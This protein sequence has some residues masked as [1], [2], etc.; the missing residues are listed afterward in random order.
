MQLLG[1]GRTAEVFLAQDGRAL[2]LF[3]ADFPAK[4]IRREADKARV[5]T[6]LCSF[7]PAF[8]GET[9]IDGRAGLLY[10]RIDGAPLIDVE[11][12]FDDPPNIES[13]ARE[14]AQLQLDI[15]AT[16]S[17]GLPTMAE[18][19]ATSIA[20]YPLISAAGRERLL[21]FVA[22]NNTAQLCHGDLH[23]DNILRQTD[24]RLRVID[25]TNA[26]SGHPLCDLERTLFMIECGLVPGTEHIDETE[27]PL[28]NA[29]A[30]TYRQAYYAEN[31]DRAN[32]DIW[33][34]LALVGRH[35]EGIAGERGIAE[36]RVREVL[37]RRGEFL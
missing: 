29:F 37:K 30:K 12:V 4:V 18:T 24:G 27:L 6:S 5:V 2:K 25:W 8:Y 1:R 7:A 17:S 36:Q 33:R 28:R 11:T 31:A 22:N 14:M 35:A 15:H 34:L 3:F 16:T 10:E 32:E 9:H 23:V 20:R 19:F 26:Y 21:D 13:I